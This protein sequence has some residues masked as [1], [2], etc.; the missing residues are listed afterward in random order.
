[1]K[2][3]FPKFLYLLLA[4]AITATI[5]SPVFGTYKAEAATVVPLSGPTTGY[6]GNAAAGENVNPYYDVSGDLLPEY[7]GPGTTVT[8][9]A[10]GQGAEASKLT[11][12]KPP[13]NAS[14]VDAVPPFF[15][16]DACVASIVYMLMWIVSWFLFLAGYIFDISMHFT[17]NISDLMTRV[18]VV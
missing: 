14:C 16:L 5:F 13:Q 18:P 8:Q 12:P 2:K 11:P 4:I 6:G 1:M 10:T 9:N 17:L 3:L 15:H 7:G